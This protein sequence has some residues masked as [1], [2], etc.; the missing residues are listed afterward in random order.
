MRTSHG[1]LLLVVAMVMA[2][3]STGICTAPA[4]APAPG[5]MFPP[6]YRCSSVLYSSGCN[7]KTLTTCENK[8]FNQLKGDGLCIRGAC[9]CS[10]MCKPPPGDI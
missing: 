4:P 5:K 2:M 6:E 7:D 3:L 1:A 10:Y 8:C 9:Q